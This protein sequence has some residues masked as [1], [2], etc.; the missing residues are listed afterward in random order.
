VPQ[1]LLEG[2]E[3]GF[4]V[5]DG[6][7]VTYHYANAEVSA[8]PA[9]LKKPNDLS[10]IVQ[11]HPAVRPDTSILAPKFTPAVALEHVIFWEPR[12]GVVPNGL[13]GSVVK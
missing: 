3:T 13:G 6:A 4:D 2:R 10:L 11:R 1:R 9:A 8:D 5:A 12:Q 7:A